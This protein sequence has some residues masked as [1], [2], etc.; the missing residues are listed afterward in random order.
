MSNQ[1]WLVQ[2]LYAKSN[3]GRKEPMFRLTHTAGFI[4]NI[5]VDWVRGCQDG[6]EACAC[7]TG[8]VYKWKQCWFM[9][10]PIV[11]IID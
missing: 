9:N 11:T 1:W 3:E 2:C 5:E 6:G 7:P 4:Q 8:K 10:E